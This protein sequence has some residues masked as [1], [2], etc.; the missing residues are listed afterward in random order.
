[1]FDVPAAGRTA[2]FCGMLDQPTFRMISSFSAGF[3]SD[4]MQK[5]YNP[6]MNILEYENYQEKKAHGNPDFPYNTYLCSIPLDFPEVP[7]HWHEQME[8]IYIKK[9]NGIVSVDF[10]S[11]EVGAGTMVFIVPGQIHAIQQKEQHKMEYENIIFDLDMLKASPMEKASTDYFGPLQEGKVLI[12]TLL[13][14]EHSLYHDVA[15]CLNGADEICR[16]FPQAYELAVKAQLYR[17]FYILFSHAATEEPGIK[18][19]RRVDRIRPIIKY[20]ENHYTEPLSTKDMA[21]VAGLSESHFMKFFKTTMGLPF[22]DYL[23]DYRLTMASRMLLS[24]DDSVLTV[25]SECGYENLSYFNRLFKRRFGM[26]PRE[27]RKG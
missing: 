20:V 2:P 7:L 12:P 15:A 18:K 13:M 19:G 6:I 11:Y 27:Y 9:G 25:A 8:I 17:L 14:P 21:R 26:T 1:M 22:I 5:W 23:N 24:S 16:G 10:V 3:L 4:S